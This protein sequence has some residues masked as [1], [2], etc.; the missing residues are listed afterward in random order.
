MGN[1]VGSGEFVVVVVKKWP[2]EAR[3]GALCDVI[4]TR[5]YSHTLPQ[6]EAG[7]IKRF[8]W[9]VNNWERTY[10]YTKGRAR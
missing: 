9:N 6:W 1:S 2:R 8:C 10:S 5:P 4:D 7:S 3:G